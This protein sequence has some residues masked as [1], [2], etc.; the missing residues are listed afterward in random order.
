[1]RTKYKIEFTVEAIPAIF[2][3]QIAPA[4]LVIQAKAQEFT[5]VIGN[6]GRNA[7]A[8]EGGIGKNIRFVPADSRIGSAI[9]L[10]LSE[11]IISYRLSITGLTTLKCSS[12]IR[13]LG[14]LWISFTAKHDLTAKDK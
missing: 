14:G 10:P 9:E 6:K 1:M 12:N 4:M 2:R 8:L 3:V 11:Y 5:E 7:A 13:A